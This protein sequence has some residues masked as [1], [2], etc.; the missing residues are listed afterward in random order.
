MCVLLAAMI[1]LLVIGHIIFCFIIFVDRVLRAN[2]VNILGVSWQTWR[3]KMNHI[4]NMRS[5]VIHLD[6]DQILLQ[7]SQLG[8]CCVDQQT[9]VKPQ[10]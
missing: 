2:N 1:V 9:Q 5:Y 10:Q 8:L 6:L 7:T 4:R 3:P